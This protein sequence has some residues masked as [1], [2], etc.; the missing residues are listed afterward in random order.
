MTVKFKCPLGDLIW[1]D[2]IILFFSILYFTVQFDFVMFIN[3]HIMAWN[4]FWS[5]FFIQNKIMSRLPMTYARQRIKATSPLHILLQEQGIVPTI[6][7]I[8]FNLLL[9]CMYQ[10]TCQLKNI[11]HYAWLQ[12]RMRNKTYRDIAK[13]MFHINTCFNRDTEINN[14]HSHRHMVG[15]FPN[16]SFWVLP[17]P[18]TKRR[19]RESEHIINLSDE[20]I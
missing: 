20:T 7:Y 14:L 10:L 11:F 2:K 13:Q 18:I 15:N 4:A 9:F 5:L 16:N 1:K 3:I 19:E 8:P 6:D 12:T 17:F